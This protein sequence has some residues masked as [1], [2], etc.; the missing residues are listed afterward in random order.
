MSKAFDA[1]RAAWWFH[2][3]GLG[4]SA[5]PAG[6]VETVLAATGWLRSVGGANP[7][8]A[9]R[10]RC[11]WSRSEVDAA[12]RELQIHELP[13]VRGC[14][15]VVPACHFQIALGAARMSGDPGDVVTARRFL[16]V[17]D[18]ELDRLEQGVVAALRA[19]P[20]LDPKQL[21]DRLGDLVR[22]LGADGKKRG[23]TTTLPLALGRLQLHGKIRRVPISGRLDEQRYTYVPWFP[24]TT[25]FP[26]PDDS[27][28]ALASEYFRW[29][30]PATPAEFQWFSGL[31]VRAVREVLATLELA[32]P[33]PGDDSLM[34]PEDVEP[35]REFLAR[36]PETDPDVVLLGSI[37]GLFH[38]RRSLA[39]FTHPEDRERP[40][41]G[42]PRGLVSAGLHDV[43]SHAIVD[44]GRLIG[45]WEYDPGAGEIE[46]VVWTERSEPVSRAIEDL[47]EFLRT[48]LGDARSFSLDSPARRQGRLA[49]FRSARLEEG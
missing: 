42:E 33:R 13:S 18:E 4:R 22:N 20:G 48:E 31:G 40:I 21:R 38:L 14:T 41:P 19:E 24:D 47:A 43:P 10:A 26:T 29:A 49:E 23:V 25:D 3:Q 5:T 12:V 39:E 7:Y 15:Y 36:P 30:G 11:G 17:T 44:R 28:R 46:S 2:R 37:D 45:L 8:L 27:I 34:L 35:Y 32:G 16:G 1:R 6:P 9:I